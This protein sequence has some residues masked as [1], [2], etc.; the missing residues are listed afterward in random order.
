MPLQHTQR[1]ANHK[2]SNEVV[3]TIQLCLTLLLDFSPFP[4]LY[5]E[6]FYKFSEVLITHLS[7][8]HWWA[9][10]LTQPHT[11]FVLTSRYLPVTCLIK[12]GEVLQKVVMPDVTVMVID[13]KGSL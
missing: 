1:M 2:H 11:A 4:F 10:S 5:R 3:G 13:L 9:T 12:S 6:S 8:D 7:G